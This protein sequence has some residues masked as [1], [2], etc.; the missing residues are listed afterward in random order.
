MS[1]FRVTNKQDPIGLQ[2]PSQK[3]HPAQTPSQNVLGA[4][5]PNTPWDCHICR[6][7]GVVPGGSIDRQSYGSPMECLDIGLQKTT[8]RIES[9]LQAPQEPSREWSP[10][11]CASAPSRLRDGG[12]KRTT[13]AGGLAWYHLWGTHVHSLEVKSV[14]FVMGTIWFCSKAL[15]KQLVV[16]NSGY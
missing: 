3:V 7:V 10:G 2:M 1:L 14:I 15:V 16:R 5:Y 9:T 11:W 12:Q 4:L 13:S 6:S 8:H